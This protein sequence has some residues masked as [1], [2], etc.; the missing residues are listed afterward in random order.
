MY[1][2]NIPNGLTVEKTS[3]QSLYVVKNELYVPDKSIIIS[4]S[5]HDVENL[6]KEHKG[7]FR[8]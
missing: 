4:H 6:V 8:L 2:I 3:D 5:L 1:N 7:G